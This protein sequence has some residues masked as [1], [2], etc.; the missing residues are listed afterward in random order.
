MAKTTFGHC[1]CGMSGTGTKGMHFGGAVLLEFD[2]FFVASCGKELMGF[3][4]SPLKSVGIDFKLA[5][6][7]VLYS[8]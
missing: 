6:H 1:L 3:M 2:K 7:Q 5:L 8:L 4:Q